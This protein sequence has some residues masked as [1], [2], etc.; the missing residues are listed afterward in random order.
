MKKIL[1]WILALGVI[2]LTFF[3]VWNSVISAGV[4]INLSWDCLVGMWKW[5]F[6][7]EEMV[8]IADEQNKNITA[9]SVVQD[10][11]LSATYMVWTVLT[12]VIIYCG[13]MYIFA[14]FP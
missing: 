7:Y 1:S 4:W 12:V 10:A 3:G 6:D 2:C 8:W 13:L 11:I 9:M 14:L 5:C